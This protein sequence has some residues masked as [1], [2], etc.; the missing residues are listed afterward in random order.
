MRLVSVE[1]CMPGMV[2]AKHIFNENGT[3]LLRRGITLT[4][5]IIQRLKEKQIS[6]VCIEEKGTED[7]EIDEDIPLTIRL[8]IGKAIK[9]SFD[10]FRNER[11]NNIAYNID[12]KRLQRIFDDLIQEIKKNKNVLSL[13]TKVCLHDFYI[14]DHSINVTI[15]ATAIAAK[16][17]YDDKRLREIAMGALFHDIGKTMIPLEIIKKPGKLTEGEFEI[18]KKHTGFGY[19]ILRQQPTIPLSSA[20]CA[21]QHH[22]RMDGSGYPKGAKRDDIHPYAKIIAVAD[23]FDALTSK[24]SYR[25]AI[26][27]HDALEILFAETNKHLDCMAVQAFQRSIAV[28]PVGASIVLNTGETGVVTKY[29]FN[30]P[31][32]PVV[33]IIRDKEGRELEEPYEIDLSEH[34]T[35]MIKQC[36][37]II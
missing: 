22:E 17:G 5:K 35:V 3:I 4:D 18:V 27:P 33:R 10:K 36:D 1:N 6:T 8:E 11:L 30:A 32:R 26:L 7:L 25:N 16:M 13:V 29:N 20:Y 15:Y 28:Y 21:F 31:G 14:Y 37:I 19:N 2:L 24:R 9:E 12:T 23:V 34:L